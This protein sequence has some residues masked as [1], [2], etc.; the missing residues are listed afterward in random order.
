M[1]GSWRVRGQPQ[2]AC[3]LGVLSTTLRRLPC[4]PYE[5]RVVQGSV[6]DYLD[7]AEGRRSCLVIVFY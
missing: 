3:R 6:G 2:E 7:E 1:N 5:I 4:A